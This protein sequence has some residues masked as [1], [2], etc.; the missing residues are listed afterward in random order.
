MRE[1]DQLT[2]DLDDPEPNEAI[3]CF[4]ACSAEGLFENAHVGRGERSGREQDVTCVP[5]EP[6]KPPSQRSA[7][8]IGDG[9]GFPRPNFDLSLDNGAADFDAPKR[10]ATA[11]SMDLGEHRPGGSP[12]QVEAEHAPKRTYAQRPKSDSH[13]I[14][15]TKGTP[16][17]KGIGDPF[18]KPGG[19]DDA[20]RLLKP[21]KEER[22]RP[23]G[24]RIEPL[25]IV[26]RNEDRPFGSDGFDG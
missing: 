24:R 13:E 12:I 22:E 23:S 25:S 2:L 14:V 6:G 3:E 17:V 10:V 4:D 1:P 7:K 16:Q 18:S 8:I 19:G 15:G 26:Y 9:E 21:A 11:G 5:G 20:H